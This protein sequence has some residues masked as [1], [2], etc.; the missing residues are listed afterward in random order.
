MHALELEVTM[1]HVGMSTE[2]AALAAACLALAVGC[3]RGDEYAQQG[4]ASGATTAALDSGRAARRDTSPSATAA[5]VAPASYISDMS[6]SNVVAALDNLDKA[7]VAIAQV[8]RTKATNDSVRAFAAKLVDD[9]KKNEDGVLSLERHV[10]LAEVPAK[11]DTTRDH[12]IHALQKLRSTP[13]GR[14]LDS[15]FVHAMVVGHEHAIANAK[16]M[17]DQAKNAQL[18]DFIG[19]TIPTLQEHLNIA[20]RLDRQLV[21]ATP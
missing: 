1:S 9:H 10:H 8:M 13:K 15:T 20:E 5:P 16:A 12:E 3:K 19:Q 18:K 14:A 17:Q 11:A 4:T 7:E 2:R 21:A 6:D